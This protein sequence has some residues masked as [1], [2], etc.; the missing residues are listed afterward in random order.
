[1][2]SYKDKNSNITA[3]D[4]DKKERIL[5]KMTLY[6]ITD[7]YI[8]HGESAFRYR[9]TP[10]FIDHL[11]IMGEMMSDNPELAKA[12]E[13]DGSIDAD[14]I[15]MMLMISKFLATERVFKQ[16]YATMPDWEKN[17]TTQVSSS[18]DIAKEEAKV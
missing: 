17:S 8:Q 10:R 4:L 9:W 16:R 2:T 7:K 13:G 3:E 15:F 12:Y 18:D 11:N 6:G 5:E 14:F 1:M